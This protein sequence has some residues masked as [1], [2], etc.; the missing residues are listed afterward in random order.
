MAPEIIE[1]SGVT[2]KADIWSVACTVIELLT[3]KPPY[4]DLEPMSALFRI[5]QDD[6]PS[7]PEGISHVNKQIN[8]QT[9]SIKRTITLFFYY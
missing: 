6:H 1:L 4:F 3:G 2:T 7:L 8:K 5:A 9:K